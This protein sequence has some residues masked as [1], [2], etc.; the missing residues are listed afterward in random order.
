[1][2]S[3]PK[4]WMEKWQEKDLLLSYPRVFM[5]ETEILNKQGVSER[6]T[7]TPSTSP[8]KPKVPA[9]ASK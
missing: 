5:F 8:S 4:A 2:L 7:R 1:M 3:D 6:K 9:P